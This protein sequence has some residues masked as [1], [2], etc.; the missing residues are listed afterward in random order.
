[1]CTYIGV[2]ILDVLYM[3]RQYGHILADYCHQWPVV[4][5]D[6]FL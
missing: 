4:S 6:I 1:M 5:D 2:Y 3:L